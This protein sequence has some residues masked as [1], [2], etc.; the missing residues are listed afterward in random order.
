MESPEPHTLVAPV[1]PH[2][3]YVAPGHILMWLHILS[4]H[5]LMWYS[6]LLPINGVAG[7][8]Y[9]YQRIALL[10]DIYY[11]WIYIYVHPHI[12]IHVCIYIC[13]YIYKCIC[14]RC[15]FKYVP[16]ATHHSCWLQHGVHSILCIWI[17]KV[18]IYTYTHICIYNMYIYMHLYMYTRIFL[19][20]PMC[21]GWLRLVGSLKIIGLFCKR[22]L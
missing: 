10:P 18:Y 17:Y 5:I 21:M 20:C 6:W 2:T 14:V 15:V 4:S 3:Q 7:A 19:L 16:M 9:S 13:I 1:A 12:F 11:I 22:A 8:T